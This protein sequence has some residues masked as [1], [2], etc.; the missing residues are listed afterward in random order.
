MPITQFLEH[1][2]DFRIDATELFLSYKLF[3]KKKYQK[4]NLSVRLYKNTN[5]FKMCEFVIEYY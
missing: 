3:V 2:K 5:F 4:G 1:E